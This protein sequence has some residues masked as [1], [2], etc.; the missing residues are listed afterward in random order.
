MTD[1]LPVLPPGWLLISLILV[2][3]ILI[4]VVLPRLW[5]KPLGAPYQLQP[6]LAPEA[7][8]TFSLI[9]EA[10]GQ[11]LTVLVAVS[12]NA[13]F[14]INPR[15]KKAERERA[16]QAIDGEQLNF[17]LC[18]PNELS[19][20]VA[21]LLTDTALTKKEQ[22]QHQQLWLQLQAS[23]LAI[24]ELSAQNL[25]SATV[26]AERVRQAQL[27]PSPAPLAQQGRIEPTLNLPNTD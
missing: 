19:P 6:L 14:T 25:P 5:R 16:W 17:L 13:L 20:V 3:I 2:L 1:K 7:H 15:L 23:G 11:E 21:I 8:T 22:K 24:I 4:L 18:E 10:A 27:Q 9:K 12:L 26:L